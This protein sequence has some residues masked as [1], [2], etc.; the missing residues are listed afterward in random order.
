M[1]EEIRNVEKQVEKSKRGK[2]KQESKGAANFVLGEDWFKN[3]NL[4][5]S[6]KRATVFAIYYSFPSNQNASGSTGTNV[7]VQKV[8]PW[9][10][11]AEPRIYVSPYALKR[12]IR[13]YWI[14]SGKKVYLREDKVLAEKNEKQV[15]GVD[16]SY[17]DIDLFGLMSAEKGSKSSAKTRP[18]TITTWGAV[19]LE[20]FHSEMD[21]NTFILST[22][23]SQSGGSIINRAISKEF[24][25]TSFHIN[26]DLIGVE[27]TSGKGVD[28][29]GKETDDQN[30]IQETKKER[31]KNFFDAL[32][33]ALQKD[34]GGSRDRPDCVIIGVAIGDKGYPNIDKKVFKS[35]EIK[36][37][38]ITKID[39]DGAHIIH[40]E[41]I[42]FDNQ[43]ITN[44]EK[45]KVEENKVIDKV[46]DQ[47]LSAGNSKGEKK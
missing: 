4:P 28:K 18:A 34:S 22:T 13:D 42:Y 35:I 45:A 9:G 24:Y 29:E 20:T 39:L 12:R 33:Y 41:P 31:L 23:Q 5:W 40:Y 46:I 11:D 44:I 1:S 7:I 36:N 2:G 21:F 26:P 38:K 14:K 25:F 16:L 30:K 27:V 47:L 8:I 37:D 19:S 10:D 15:R 32:K 6:G 17:I 3:N 43:A